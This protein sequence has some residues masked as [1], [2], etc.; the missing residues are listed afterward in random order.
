MSEP[1]YIHR[2]DSI[3]HAGVSTTALLPTDHGTLKNAAVRAV[4][5]PYR[6]GN[7]KAAWWVLTG[8][9]FAFKWPKAGDLEKALGVTAK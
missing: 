9:A 4:G 6:A 2:I 7:I 5:E 3:Y 1:F 8:R